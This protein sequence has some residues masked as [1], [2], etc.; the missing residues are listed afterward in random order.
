MK[1]ETIELRSVDLG[2]V[3][4]ENC[5][6]VVTMNIDIDRFKKTPGSLKKIKFDFSLNKKNANNSAMHAIE[7]AQ[8]TVIKELFGGENVWGELSRSYKKG[9]HKRVS[10]FDCPDGIT[11]V[12]KRRSGNHF[13]FLFY[14]KT[15]E[16]KKILDNLLTEVDDK[17]DKEYVEPGSSLV[18]GSG[19]ESD[20]NLYR[21]ELHFY[22]SFFDTSIK[23][24]ESSEDRKE[25]IVHLIRLF[26]VKLREEDPHYK[27]PFINSL[28][29]QL[30]RINCETVGKFKNI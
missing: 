22:K 5:I 30:K 3:F 1:K 21:V 2:H 27:K 29:K 26:Q 10:S 11:L 4:E 17:K 23:K 7:H 18:D 28:I 8:R 9:D 20:L 16:Q 12:K 14:N 24:K 15:V 25:L 13:A 19:E 6:R